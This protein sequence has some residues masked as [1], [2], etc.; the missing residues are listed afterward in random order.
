MQDE[1]Q[2]QV[3]VY[4]SE[5][6]ADLVRERRDD[7]SVAALREVLRRHDAAAMSQLDAFEAYVADAE[8]AEPERFPL[9]RW[10]KAA[11]ADPQKR[12]KQK[13]AFALRVGGA[14]LYGRAA[15]DALERDLVPLV[16]NG[17]V[18]RLSRHDTDPA[19]NLPIPSEYRP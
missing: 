13:L 19:S 12:A 4:L 14:E 18:T 6:A 17:I 8:A 16:G 10:T 15:A 7:P 1:W 9:Y 2:H 11:L 3:R 5:A